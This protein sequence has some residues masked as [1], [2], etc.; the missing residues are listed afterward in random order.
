MAL[1]GGLLLL[2]GHA[3]GLGSPAA[4]FAQWLLDGPLSMLRNV[5]KVDA[6]VRLPLAIGVGWAATCS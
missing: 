4:P 6:L 1:I 2:A 3:G 5:H